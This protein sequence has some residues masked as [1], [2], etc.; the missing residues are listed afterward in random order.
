[1]KI[2]LEVFPYWNN[3]SSLTD[4]SFL[5]D[6]L[7]QIADDMQKTHYHYE[8][9]S[10]YLTIHLFMTNHSIDKHIYLLSENKNPHLAW[11]HFH[12]LKQP[13]SMAPSKSMSIIEWQVVVMRS[14][15]TRCWIQT[16]RLKEC[17]NWRSSVCKRKKLHKNTVNMCSRTFA[18]V[19][20]DPRRRGGLCCHSVT[21]E[22]RLQEIANFWRARRPFRWV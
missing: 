2:T 20:S 1:M 19:V 11:V 4:N 16:H 7:I 15:K 9:N 22:R 18:C 8:R 5:V 21:I 6:L 10:V 14:W 17:T 3:I 13:R 12:Q